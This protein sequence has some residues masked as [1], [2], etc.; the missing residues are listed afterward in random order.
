MCYRQCTDSL[1]NCADGE[2]Y[3]TY[4]LVYE[5][6]LCCSGAVLYGSVAHQVPYECVQA[7]NL[8]VLHRCKDVGT[9][10]S[11]ERLEDWN[12]CMSIDSIVYLRDQRLTFNRASAGV[13]STPSSYAPTHPPLAQLDIVPKSTRPPSSPS[14]TADS[15]RT[16]Q[17]SPCL[18]MQRMSI[19]LSV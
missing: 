18:K 13:V 5:A 4:E 12:C 7:E 3:G 1:P 15:L 10:I 16:P 6:L 17:T 8:Q 19:S 9:A 2:N 11:D 14:S